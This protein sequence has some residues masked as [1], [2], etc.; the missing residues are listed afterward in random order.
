MLQCDSLRMKQ[1]ETV[2]MMGA[3][4]SGK[5]T[6]LR[7]IAGL[8]PYGRGRIVTPPESSML[9]IPQR[10]Y[11]PQR[12]MRQLITYPA[13]IDELDSA[14]VYEALTAC[15]L[16]HLVPQLDEEQNWSLTLSLGEQQRVGFV[17]AILLRPKWLFLDE[18]TSALDADSET[19]LYA[20]LKQRLPGTTIFTISHRSALVNVH[21]RILQTR[22]AGTM[23]ILEASAKIA[24]GREKIL[25]GV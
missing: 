19:H 20:L 13:R 7:A 21:Q 10:P 24:A 11:L 18:S 12:P 9:F 25:T 14:K 15:G 8:W 4:G 16:A 5:S 17:R 3:S 1:G 2:L 6:L 22:R 23:W